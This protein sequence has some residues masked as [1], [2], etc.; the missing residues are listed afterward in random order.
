VAVAK[1]LGTEPVIL[2]GIRDGRLEKGLA[3]GADHVINVRREDLV[4]AVRKITAGR[5]ADYVVECSGAANAL[6]EAACMVNRGGEICLA[7]FPHEQVPA[8]VVHLVRNNI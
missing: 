8:D 7:A 1:A 2:T 4:A 6:N 5:G 3:L